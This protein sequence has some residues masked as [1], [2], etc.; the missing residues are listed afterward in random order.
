MLSANRPPEPPQHADEWDAPG[1]RLTEEEAA[2]ILADAADYD[3]YTLRA[4]RTTGEA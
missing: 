1:R 2:R 3:G 4:P